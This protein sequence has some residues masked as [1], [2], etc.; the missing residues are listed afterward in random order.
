MQIIKVFKIYDWDGGDRDELK[1]YYLKRE[2]NF[3]ANL[4]KANH[5]RHFAPESIVILDN[6]QE[7]KQYELGALKKKALAKLTAQEKLLLGISEE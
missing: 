5:N 2:E 1:S 7:L 3:D 4:L 6:L